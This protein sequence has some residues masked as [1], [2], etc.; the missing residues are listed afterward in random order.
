MSSLTMNFDVKFTVLE[1]TTYPM[2]VF[3]DGLS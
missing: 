1:V 3:S 2:V